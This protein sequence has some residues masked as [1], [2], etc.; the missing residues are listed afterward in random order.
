LNYRFPKALPVAEGYPVGIESISELIRFVQFAPFRISRLW[1]IIRTPAAAAKTD[2]LGNIFDLLHGTDTEEAVK[3]YKLDAVS[4][5]YI[6]SHGYQASHSNRVADILASLPIRREQYSF[7]DVGCGKGRVLIVAEEIGF[8]NVTGVEISSALCETARKNLSICGIRGDILN[9]DAAKF[10]IP[11]SACVLFLYSP[12]NRWVMHQFRRN[13]ERRLK[14]SNEDIWIVYFSPACRRALDASNKLRVFRDFGDTVIYRGGWETGDERAVENSK[15]REITPLERPGRVSPEGAVAVASVDFTGAHPE[16]PAPNAGLL[17]GSR[18]IE[19][20]TLCFENFV[21]EK[22][23]REQRT[24][25]DR[26]I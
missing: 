22:Q 2:S 24:E 9:S 7:V 18:G 25:M 13:V 6:H 23:I 3:V 21:D 8:R 26:G 15:S 11:E 12:F 19:A 4:S 14:H 1:E 5:S 16:A 20:S 10:E 17:T